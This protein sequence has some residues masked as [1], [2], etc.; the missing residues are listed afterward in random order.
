MSAQTFDYVVV[1]GGSA[2]CV[3]ASRLSED[4][5]VSVCLLEAGGSDASVFIQAPAGVAA[6]LPGPFKNWAFKTVPQKGLNGRRGYQ[7]RGKVLGGSSST[8]AMLYVRG[9]RSDYDHWAA[10]GNPG[11]SYDEV[12]PCFRRAEHNETH[13]E[14][15]YHGTGGPLNVAELRC[16]SPLNQ[17]FIAA[18]ALHGVP[19]VADYNGP[20]QFGAFMYQVT[21]KNGERC[22]VAKGY[23]T[24]HLARPNLCVK[25]GAQSSRVLFEGRRA[26][27]VE[28]VHGGRTQQVR[29]QREV[30]VSSGAFGSPQLLMLSGIGDGPALQ[31]LGIPVLHHLPGVG[32]NLHDHIDHV[33]GWRARS[34]SPTFGFSLRGGM[35]ITKA[36]GQWRRE[37]TGL[38]TSNFAESGAFVR[39][40]PDVEVPDLQM[41]FVVALVDDH[42]RKMHWG[43]GYS[44]HIEV[45]RPHSRGSVRLASPDPRAAPLI[46]PNFLADERDLA[47]LVKGVQLQM[48]MMA[49]P[50]FDRWRGSM[51]Y[52]VD[53]NDSAAIAEDIRNRADTQYHPV[54]T[55]K[56]GRDDDPMAVVDARLRVHGIAGLRVVDASI[57]PVLCGGNTNA[58]T[59]MIGEKAADMIRADAQA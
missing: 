53:R 1:G 6:T 19:P 5:R 27:A 29:A 24:P 46:D 13:A 52:P 8:N 37:R 48:D 16:P 3:L 23:L 21:Q 57:M 26:C 33:Q 54:G 20:D 43:H 11:W 18:A 56:M 44:C 30:I 49:S 39:S 45:L 34:D 9:H 35:A 31:A 55:C 12:L 7:P 2:G 25:T 17:A 32:E 22:S 47:L 40:A 38:V 15:L 10:L 51:L 58:P 14:G 42:N 50:P 41:V 36:M 28:F 59:V 4:P